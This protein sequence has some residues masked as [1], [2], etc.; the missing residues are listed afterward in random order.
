MTLAY[1]RYGQSFYRQRNLSPVGASSIYN[2][3]SFAFA[4]NAA[5]IPSPDGSPKQSQQDLGSMAIGDTLSVWDERLQLILGVRAQN[6]KAWNF[7][8]ADWRGHLVL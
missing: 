6:I 2:P 5:L 4:P 3:A 7:N 8:T 1:N